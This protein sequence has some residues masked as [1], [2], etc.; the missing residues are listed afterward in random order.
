M[1]AMTV[2]LAEI[3]QAEERLRGVAN[4]TPVLTSRTLDDRVGGQVFV[5]AENY[6][7][8]GA[9]KFRG[10]YNALCRLTSEQRSKGVLTFS[11]GN[12]AGGLALAGKLLGVP[13]TVVMPGDAP[14]IKRAATE[15]YGAEVIEYVRDEQSREEL[16]AKLASERGL[17][18]I[19]P[20][21]HPD[22]IAGQ[23]TVALELLEDV[24][25]LDLLLVC[26]GGG[27]LLAGC[28]VAA[29]S[30]R[31]EIRVVGVEPA[32]ADDAARSFRLGQIQTIENP[33]TIADG[34]RTPYVGKLNFE[35]IQRYVDD[36]VTVSE[37]AI[38][39]ATKFYWERMK[40]VVEPTGALT[41]AALLSGK[42]DAKGLR[43]GIVVSGGNAD[44]QDLAARWAKSGEHAE[45]L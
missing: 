31:R 19:P 36:I 3:R 39:D 41:L 40:T 5:K 30:L 15:G 6:Q 11:S 26:V 16:G 7:R 21:D 1:R 25:D 13:I 43:V 34:A 18:V 32:Q 20:Y 14:P 10:A 22:I 33:Q 44:I 24:P 9:F 37:A 12:H 28:A 8:G 27:G 23:G 42:V 38:L 29:K 17:T 2:G 35:L 45:A 4:R